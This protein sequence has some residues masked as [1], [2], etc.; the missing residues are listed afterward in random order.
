M[1]DNSADWASTGELPA[2]N[3]VREDPA[4]LQNYPA[5]APFLEELEY[6]RY[7][8]VS[9]GITN[10]MAEV[11]TGVNEA[12]LGKKSPKEALDDAAAKATQLLQQNKAQYGG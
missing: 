6:A 9:P 1:N 2:Q 3:S 10:A 7:E 12:V 5:L 4:L 8:T 11:T